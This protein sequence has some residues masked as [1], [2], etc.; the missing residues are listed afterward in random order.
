MCAAAA[1]DHA[2]HRG[3]GEVGMS[4]GAIAS[5]TIIALCF[6]VWAVAGLVE[7][8]D[9]RIDKKLAAHRRSCE[10]ERDQ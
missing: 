1:F 10:W 5:A 3:Y 7:Y 6:F 2:D 8:I 4:S 9:E